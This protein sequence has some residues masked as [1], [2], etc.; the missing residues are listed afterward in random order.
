MK[1]RVVLLCFLF[2]LA[3]CGA[4]N[5]VTNEGLEGYEVKQTFD[6]TIEDNFVFRLVS[7]KEEYE[8]GEEVELYGEIIYI[9]EGE[10]V[11]AHASSAVLFEIKEQ[12]RD[13]ELPFAVQ[14]IHIETKLAA[15]EPY[16]EKYV[17]QGVF[18]FEDDGEQ[19][20]GFIEDFKK[21]RDFPPG[22]YTVTATTAFSDGTI[23]RELEAKVDFKVWAEEE[24][25]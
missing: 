21:R 18:S 16:R 1:M 6:E 17:K 8:A 22:Y 12:V 9:G 2:I 25:E 24:E 19:Y 7:G 15:G 14:D 4:A 10:V 11:I 3:G 23:Q 5:E 20:A 13:Y